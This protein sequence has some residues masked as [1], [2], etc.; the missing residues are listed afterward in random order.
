[1][2]NVTQFPIVRRAVAADYPEVMR[3]AGLVWD[4]NGLF[5]MSK[6]KMDW[7]L[8]RVLDPDSIPQ[9]DMGVRGFMGVIGPPGGRLEALIL[10]TLGSYWYTDEV[11]LEEYATFVDPDHRKSNHAKTL[12]KYA[13]HL[14][15]QI[16]IPLLIG[17][18]SNERTEAKVRLYRRL[19]GREAGAFFLYGRHTGGKT[20]EQ[21]GNKSGQALPASS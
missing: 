15:D 13:Q 3:L 21:N 18:L 9:G 20:M 11:V 8:T 7:L 19:L 1:M 5:K 17:V 12:I 16:G 6:R 4:E 14:S 2:S 10:L